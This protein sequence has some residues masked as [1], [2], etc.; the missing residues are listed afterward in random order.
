VITKT[1]PQNHNQLQYKLGKIINMTN[2][3][4]LRLYKIKPGKLSVWQDWCEKL[5]G[6]YSHAASRTLGDEGLRYEFFIIFK[7][8]GSNYT[9]GGGILDEKS[10]PKPSDKTLALNINHKQMI[11]D[12]L[13]SVDT[14]EYLYL[15]KAI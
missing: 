14:A 4:P 15:I 3:P 6:E 12:C 8:E 13:E 9:L 10:E 11:N 1:R 5:Q 2:Q 7:I